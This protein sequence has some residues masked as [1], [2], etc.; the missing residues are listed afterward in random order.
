MMKDEEQVKQA[1]KE[2]LTLS[3]D[4]WLNKYGLRTIAEGRGFRKAL[5]WMVGELDEKTVHVL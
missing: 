4:V 3:T 1:L 2:T 5:E